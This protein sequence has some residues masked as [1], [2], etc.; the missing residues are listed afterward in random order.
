M[1]F[2]IGIDSV[3][4]SSLRH[5]YAPW[6]FFKAAGELQL[7]IS[8]VVK[9]LGTIGEF[10]VQILKGSS[11]TPAFFDALLVTWQLLWCLFSSQLLKWDVLCLLVACS[12]ICA[13]IFTKKRWWW[14]GKKE[15]SVGVLKV[16]GIRINR[17]AR[18]ATTTWKASQ[19][20]VHYLMI[21]H[22]CGV[23]VWAMQKSGEISGQHVYDEEARGSGNGSSSQNQYAFEHFSGTTWTGTNAVQFQ[24]LFRSFPGWGRRVPV[25]V[26]LHPFDHRDKQVSMRHDFDIDM[27]KEIQYQ[28]EA[29]MNLGFHWE[30]RLWAKIMPAPTGESQRRRHFLLAQIREEAGWV[31]VLVRTFD[32][33]LSTLGTV[34]LP[35]RE[36]GMIEME[37]LFERILPHHRCE[38]D[39][40]CFI[41]LKDIVD[42]KGS[43]ALSNGQ[44]FHAHHRPKFQ[45]SICPSQSLTDS[46]LYDDLRSESLESMSIERRVNMI[47]THDAG[48]EAQNHDLVEGDDRDLD[49]TSLMQKNLLGQQEMTVGD[50]EVCHNNLV[51]RAEYERQEQMEEMQRQ[52]QLFQ[53]QV[54][55][56]IQETVVVHGEANIREEV[57][58]ILARR[59]YPVIVVTHGLSTRHLGT[60][61][62]ELDRRFALDTM[63]LIL[64][65]WEAWRFE[66]QWHQMDLYFVDPQPFDWQREDVEP[67]HILLDFHPHRGGVAL[68]TK[69]NMIFREGEEGE[70]ESARVHRFT[71]A[72]IRDAVGLAHMCAQMTCRL[73]ILRMRT[74][75]MH[76]QIEML[77]GNFF[78]FDIFRGREDVSNEDTS[79]LQ[80]Q[81]EEK[82]TRLGVLTRSHPWRTDQV[83]TF[84]VLTRSRFARPFGTSGMLTRSSRFDGP[85]PDVVTWS[86]QEEKEDDEALW[87]QTQ[88]SHTNNGHSAWPFRL[89]R[90]VRPKQS[91]SGSLPSRTGEGTLLHAQ[92]EHDRRIDGL[93]HQEA[94]RFNEE[95]TR[96]LKQDWITERAMDLSL[97]RDGKVLFVTF[98]IEEVQV[99]VEKR[100]IQ[101]FEM[102]D[103]LDV[104]V[105]LR[106]PWNPDFQEYDADL[107][108]VEPQ[109]DPQMIGGTE[110]VVVIIDFM[111]QH[112]EISILITTTTRW[113][114]SEPTHDTQVHRVSPFT[115]C[116]E[117]KRITGMTM[118][119]EVNAVCKCSP[120]DRFRNADQLLLLGAG[121]HVILDIDFRDTECQE[122]DGILLMQT[123]PN[124]GQFGKEEKVENPEPIENTKQKEDTS[125]LWVYAFVYGWEQPLKIWHADHPRYDV[126]TYMVSQVIA[127]DPHG[128]SFWN[129][130]VARTIPQPEDLRLANIP[131]YLVIH[132]RNLRC[133]ENPILLDVIWEDIQAIVAWGPYFSA[134]RWRKVKV[135]HFRVNRETLIHQLG[136]DEFCDQETAG[137]RVIVAGV[138]WHSSDTQIK[139]IEETAYI[140]VFVPMKQPTIEAECSNRDKQQVQNTQ[141]SQENQNDGEVKDYGNDQEEGD[142]TSMMTARGSLDVRRT[143]FTQWAHV[144]K[145]GTDPPIYIQ[146]SFQDEGGE[147]QHILECMERNFRVEQGVAIF[148]I[149][150]Q[151][152]DLRQHDATGYLAIKQ[153]D[154][155]HENVIIMVD[156][157]F[158]SNRPRSQNPAPRDGWRETLTTRAFVTRSLFLQNIGL[159][160]FCLGEHDL[161]ILWHGNQIWVSQDG[162]LR[163]VK[164]GDYLR[165][166]IRRDQDDIPLADQ[167]RWAQCGIRAE[168]FRSQQRREMAEWNHRRLRRDEY[169]DT[170]DTSSFLQMKFQRYRPTFATIAREILPPPGN[171]HVRFGEIEIKEG[172]QR[173][174]YR[175][176]LLASRFLDDFYQKLGEAKCP[177]RFMKDLHEKIASHSRRQIQSK[178]V[179]SLEHDL[180]KREPTTLCLEHLL[181]KFECPDEKSFLQLDMLS[182][183]NFEEQHSTAVEEP[184][185][186]TNPRLA[187][188]LHVHGKKVKVDGLQELHTL[189]TA[190][191]HIALKPGIPKKE[192][193]DGNFFSNLVFGR[194]SGVSAHTVRIY[195]DGSCL[196]NVKHQ[197]EIAAW[198][199]VVTLVY[200]DG[201][202]S[203]I[204][205]LASALIPHG[206]PEHTGAMRMAADEAEADALIWASRWAIQAS[207]VK[208]VGNLEIFTDSRTKAHGVEGLW[209]L[210]DNPQKIYLQGTYLMLQQRINTKTFWVKAHNGDLYNETVDH[211]AKSYARFPTEMKVDLPQYALGDYGDALMWIWSMER[212][213]W[214]E[215]VPVVLD[216]HLCFRVP[217][218][219]ENPN[220]SKETEVKPVGK[221]RITFDLKLLTYNTN[222]LSGFRAG[223][224]KREVILGQIKDLG[225]QVFGLQETRRKRELQWSSDSMFGFSTSSKGGQGGLDLIFRTDVPF[226]ESEHGKRYFQAQNFT[227]IYASSHILMVRM[228][229]EDLIMGFCVAHAPHEMSTLEEKSTFW[230][231]MR[232]VFDKAKIQEVCVMIDANARVG[233]SDSAGCGYAYADRTN[234]NGEFLQAFLHEQNLYLPSTYE[235]NIGDHDNDQGTWQHA[236]GK[237][238]RI[239]YCALP[240]TWMWAD[241]CQTSVHD[242]ETLQDFRDHRAAR[243]HVKR[244]LVFQEVKKRVTPKVDR[245][246][247]TTQYGKEVIQSHMRWLTERPSKSLGARADVRLDNLNDFVEDISIH[248]FLTK[249]R[250]A[251][252][253]WIMP[254]VWENLGWVKALQR[255]VTENKRYQKIAFMRQIFQS[256]RCPQAPLPGKNWLRDLQM[257][258]A[259]K[260]IQLCWWRPWVKEQLKMAEATFLEKCA[261][262]Y[263]KDCSEADDSKLWK[264]IGRFLPKA[265]ARKATRILR[266]TTTTQ[267]FEQQFATAEDAQSMD[268]P[269]LQMML[270]ERSQKAIESMLKVGQEIEDLP[271]IQELED[272]LRRVKL[273]KSVFGPV[274]P[275]WV[276]AAPRQMALVLFEAYMDYFLYAQ[277]PGRSKGGWCCPLWKGKM[278]VEDVRNYR[279]ILVSAL[280]AKA[281]HAVLRSRLIRASRQIIHGL[282]LGG[283]P[284]ME[285]QYGAHTLALLRRRAI[286][287]GKS[288]AVLYFDLTQAFYRV[289]RSLVTGDP[290][291][292]CDYQ[293]D[294]DVTL[295]IMSKMSAC[296]KAGIPENLHAALQETLA[297]SWFTMRSNGTQRAS[298]WVSRRGTRPGDPVADYAF[299]MVMASLLDD[300]NDAL[301]DD[302]PTYYDFHGEE[303]VIPPIVWVDDVA[304]VVETDK[305]DEL[306]KKVTKVAEKMHS[307]CSQHGL[308]MN[309]SK[310]KSEA[311]VRFM[312]PGAAKV[313]RQLK[314]EGYG[315]VQ[316]YGGQATSLSFGIVSKYV[317]LGTM[318]TTAASLDL[319]IRLRLA[320]AQQSY[321]NIKKKVLEN[322]A[323]PTSK[324]VDLA[325]GIVV[326]RLLFG[327]ET[328]LEISKKSLGKL[329]HFLMKIYRTILGCLNH[330]RQENVTDRHVRAQFPCGMAEESIR[331]RRLRYVRRVYHHGPRILQDLLE[332]QYKDTE[333]SW[334]QMVV[335][336]I[337][338]LKQWC[339][340]EQ[341][342]DLEPQN[343]ESCKHMM[344]VKGKTWDKACKRA[345]NCYL[346][347]KQEEARSTDN[348]SDVKGHGVGSWTCHICGTGFNSGAAM[349][350]HM[351]RLHKV[352]ATER[353][354]IDSVQCLAC[355]RHYHTLQRNRQH[356]QK[357][358]ECR[359]RLQ[360]ILFPME[361]DEVE[362][363]AS[364]D[365]DYRVPWI[366]A[367]GPLLPTKTQ[368]LEVCPGKTFPIGGE[369]L[370]ECMKSMHDAACTVD[371]RAQVLRMAE[372]LFWVKDREFKNLFRAWCESFTHEASKWLKNGI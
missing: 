44:Y 28:V 1:L 361:V 67:I 62:I 296:E 365:S 168:D 236:S 29:Q 276:K 86:H 113:H 68:L 93:R 235:E 145:I 135:I 167:W 71:G 81:N 270:H 196:W 3:N 264:V 271:T 10:W 38:I 350:T 137:C 357:S 190:E 192:M 277:E 195:T 250:K 239:D 141:R 106:R 176:D 119:C 66:V 344:R 34:L 202:Q 114:D 207:I 19:F 254:S 332:M 203:L 347:S 97:L 352:F 258:R 115:N 36:D 231:T 43:F 334:L 370:E 220:L 322:E 134:P 96:V 267:A 298:H 320:K 12:M 46:I 198:A 343:L 226:A 193:F 159:A 138:P 72:D 208:E 183:T 286:D 121:Q 304:I 204:G 180:E 5:F 88:R 60:K 252:P 50:S 84:G 297:G 356:L 155:P 240:R 229:M 351:H 70:Y 335:Q 131:A 280:T 282:Q 345:M 185:T 162:N 307:I 346:Q 300:L 326:S 348:P 150:P 339:K 279:S 33:V 256:W 217:E 42:W 287:R 186:L 172:D 358:A 283:L 310:G 15:K 187:S 51:D 170:S 110:A 49:G 299:T 122:D 288:H 153:I 164:N 179:I 120:G 57:R 73:S 301:R 251:R 249:R 274:V 266:Y 278:P 188:S 35:F 212:S 148:R 11:Q 146:R 243:V 338:W 104:L 133:Y 216:D 209:N 291:G 127:Q 78:M 255:Q 147:R 259:R 354:L 103:F 175:D 9:C 99:G 213:T 303:T 95:H 321:L 273:D 16:Q 90:E 210:P 56:L 253:S 184:M 214:N 94:R 219:L 13:C 126:V 223:L 360:Q 311:M 245:Q 151:P 82:K 228:F 349:A 128:V 105:Q 362:E 230:A 293:K 284:M 152:S 314:Q 194:R 52:M 7:Q 45:G 290:L 222:T 59:D 41:V 85:I 333:C 215:D 154:L 18:W 261:D 100:W 325:E 369:L 257:E 306:I 157:E 238:A 218:A 160:E 47:P 40:D 234:E 371:E 241:W 353:Y 22:H 163:F 108:F 323:I 112:R 330:V 262:D 232:M 143:P 63:H 221:S 225:V 171:G 281:F 8:F 265:R 79:L 324:R 91:A 14:L 201:T 87:M 136:L 224:P 124:A 89:S 125:P 233:G 260:T 4:S 30:P 55:Q 272:A 181:T 109:P 263:K 368:W 337:T 149:N 237:L 341:F 53:D 294:E 363:T 242:I 31:S 199:F 244:T 312:G 132:F 227:V 25:S 197:R 129:Y 161:C 178:R 248:F 355:L 23:E 342:A 17:S 315:C 295:P 48:Q 285:V 275:E 166:Q 174:R 6:E 32:H 165:V 372:E 206:Q 116:R 156:Y 117:I 305:A 269:Q 182:P 292:Y 189:M 200:E 328:W 289:Q 54:R 364:R 144:F 101:T 77:S 158:I 76:Q 302:F 98:G 327:S 309:L 319:E 173:S 268:T 26:W 211:C 111:P 37:A 80:F 359:E 21:W 39:F 318:Q 61:Q 247:M 123:S 2:N 313:A 64:K 308:E 177:N 65:I 169:N 130:H 69:I 140:Q 74:F 366:Q 20:L 317:H 142:Q 83:Q 92:I 58:C 75:Q 246:L 102:E 27:A 316:M 191:D 139:R 329:D 205:H 107:L 24:R 367:H 340:D 118:V 336:D 331:L